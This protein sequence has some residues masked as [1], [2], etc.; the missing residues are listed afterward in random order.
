MISVSLIGICH[1]IETAMSR[2]GAELVPTDYW[3]DEVIIR[4]YE[5]KCLDQFLQ[6]F[7]VYLIT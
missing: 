7:M 3:I 5:I 1:V 6:M 2:V 4:R